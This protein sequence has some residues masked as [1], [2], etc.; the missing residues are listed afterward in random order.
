MKTYSLLALAIVA[1]SA[2]RADAVP[3]QV[4]L[5]AR[6]VDAGTPIT[7][8]HTFTVRIFDA[9]S[10]G[11]QQ[12]TENDAATANDGTV[13]LTLGDQ[14]AL[15]ATVLDGGPLWIELQVDSTVLSPRLQITSAAYAVRAGVAEDAELLGGMPATAFAAVNH[16]HTGA[17]LPV[18]TTLSCTG[19]QKVTGLGA[20]GS[21]VCGTDVDT[22]VTL[23]GSGTAITAAHSDHAHTGTYLPVGATLSCTGTQKV[24]GVNG[25]NGSVVCGNDTDST[26][27]AGTGL[28]LTGN[29]FSVN[30]AGTGAAPTAARADH[31][32]AEVCPAGYT[33]YS[34][35]SGS[36]SP[37]CIKRVVNNM[38]WNNAAA[39]CFLNHSA[40]QLCTYTE[41]RIGTAVGGGL[42]LSAGFW[43]GDRVD[44][45]WVL[46]VNG[47]NPLDFDEAIEVVT[48]SVIG[49]G[50]Y[51]CQRAH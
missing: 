29:S 13:Y 32:H 38:T 43:M 27:A 1:A 26:Y 28:S 23:A 34:G 9:A 10:G 21:V 33:T 35:N 22:T 17:Y 5:T 12:W 47:T 24:T 44:D 15:D 49:P 30:F 48:T 14:S 16:S 50:F 20:N 36:G 46:R 51:C 39:D 7:G 45:N 3:E 18:G 4:G 25:V 8:A 40:G 31:T 42:T 41:M 19:T 37:L 11:A 2:S 6:V